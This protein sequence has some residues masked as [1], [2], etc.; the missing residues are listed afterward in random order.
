MVAGQVRERDLN[1]GRSVFAETQCLHAFVGLLSMITSTIMAGRQHS[2][3]KL[4]FACIETKTW[5]T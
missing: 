2:F 4:R 1:F 5:I 3:V